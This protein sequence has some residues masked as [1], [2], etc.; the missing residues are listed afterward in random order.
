MICSA[1]STRSQEVNFPIG[2]Q[3][4]NSLKR[5]KMPFGSEMNRKKSHIGKLQVMLFGTIQSE[6]IEN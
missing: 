3:N 4:E 5:T 1:L 6:Q 2:P